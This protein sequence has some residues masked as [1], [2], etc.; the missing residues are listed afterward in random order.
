[1]IPNVVRDDI[2]V[3]FAC[4]F[5]TEKSFKRADE[6]VSLCYRCYKNCQHN[7][8]TS[9]EMRENNDRAYVKNGDIFFVERCEDCG[10]NISHLKLLR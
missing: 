6:G 3:E 5:C 1:M 7:R 4:R 8:Y 9:Y 10:E 2:V